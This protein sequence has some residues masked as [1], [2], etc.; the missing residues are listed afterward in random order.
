MHELLV[1]LF[2]GLDF[3]KFSAEGG[4]P[5][6][7]AEGAV[8]E[9]IPQVVAVDVVVD[10]GGGRQ[11]LAAALGLIDRAV[12]HATAASRISMERGLRVLADRRAD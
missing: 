9:A 5:H 2:R 8:V 4:I 12:V 7:N 10:A 6:A 1:G 11:L 3:E